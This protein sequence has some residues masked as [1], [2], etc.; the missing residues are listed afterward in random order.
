MLVRANYPEFLAVGEA[1]DL[2]A[3]VN[4]HQDA[5]WSLHWLVG[6]S[7]SAQLALL[8][9]MGLCSLGVAVG[10]RTPLSTV[11]LLVFTVSLHNNNPLIINGGDRQLA[12]ALLWACLLPVGRVWSVD[13][14]LRPAE[15]TAAKPMPDHAPGSTWAQL[16]YIA[17][18]V[19]LYWMA[20]SHK[21]LQG[22]L[23]E[24]SAVWFAFH[25]DS[26]SWPAARQ[27]LAF[28]ALL[29]LFS[30]GAYLIQW[31][32]PLLLIWP[33]RSIVPRLLGVGL[34]ASMHLGFLPFLKLG[35]FPWVSLVCL[36]PLLPG[37]LWQR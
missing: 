22:W 20:A 24:G 32:A 1:I 14:L 11:L 4:R 15:A 16:G 3:A 5:A 33:S 36:L 37:Q 7:H 35:Q 9:V 30:R 23:I 27:L 25:I 13:Q 34:L 28:P 8:T 31:A 19:L 12:T 29:Q 2:S 26:F 17:Q 21:F 10:Y 18:T 6:S